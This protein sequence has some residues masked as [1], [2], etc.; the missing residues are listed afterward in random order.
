M[1]LQTERLR[2]LEQIRAFL[3]GNVEVDLRPQGRDAAY[4]FVRRTLARLRCEARDRSG[5][6]EYLAKTT[7][8]SRAQVTRLVAQRRKTGRVED[9]RG[10]N[11]GRPFARIYTPRRPTSPC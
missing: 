3:K 10:A 8:L 6:G 2:T 9:R 4:G 1:T 5:K 7:G 11:S